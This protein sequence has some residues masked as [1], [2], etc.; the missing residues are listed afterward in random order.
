MATVSGFGKPLVAA[1]AARRGMSRTSSRYEVRSF[2]AL[3]GDEDVGLFVTT[4]GFI[5][6]AEIGARNQGSRRVTL[7][8]LRQ[9]VDLWMECYDRL[10]EVRKR[11][12][13][14]RPIYFLAPEL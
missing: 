7:I 12:L 4:G 5:K 3:L 8:D 9:L 14:L 1:I 13:P 2:M 6:D 10:T 11:R